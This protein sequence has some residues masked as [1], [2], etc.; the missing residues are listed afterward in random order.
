MQFNRIVR[1]G[2]APILCLLGDIC[3]PS[4]K[5]GREFLEW[6][7]TN[8]D[9]VLWI[10]G[11]HEVSK[12]SIE[13]MKNLAYT[14]P[15]LHVMMN[16]AWKPSP[17]SDYLLL[18]T[19]LVTDKCARWLDGHISESQDMNEKTIVLSYKCP[20][21]KIFTEPDNKDKSA[22]NY[23]DMIRSPVITWLMGDTYNC[24]RIGVQW[25]QPS[26]LGACFMG[27]NS[28]HSTLFTDYKRDLSLI[29]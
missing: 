2:V 26:R 4:S 7:G 20:T 3:Q 18:G 16:T 27:S 22:M 10:P 14:I 13:D 12:G 21:Y 19:P 28:F 29:L 9:H 23:V 24:Y 15:R 1:P 6:C 5:S 11:K 8:W 17:T 25:T